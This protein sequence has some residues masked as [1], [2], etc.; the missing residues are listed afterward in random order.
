MTTPYYKQHWIEIDA[1]RL[2]V[3]ESLLRYEPRMSRCSPHSTCRPGL[4]VLDIGSG[5]GSTTLELGRRVGL[6]GQVIGVDINAEFVARAGTK[7]LEAG[8]PQVSFQ[9][10]D[11]PPLPFD[12]G[13]FERV[14][15][16]NVLEYVDSAQ[17]TVQDIARVTQPGGIIVLIDK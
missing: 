3:Y 8:L 2:S 10:A 9:Q 5:P 13:T 12:S 16:K 4:S 17:Q 1:A 14:L 15:C 11:F 7:A 6:T